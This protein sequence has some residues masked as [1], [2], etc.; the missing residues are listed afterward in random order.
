MSRDSCEL[1]PE[2]RHLYRVAGRQLAM[3]ASRRHHMLAPT[4]T[5]SQPTRKVLVEQ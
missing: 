2:T 5:L 3:P 1:C 4:S